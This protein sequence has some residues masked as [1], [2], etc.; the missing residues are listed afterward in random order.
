MSR[1]DFLVDTYA[2]ERMKTLSAWS[3]IPDDRL[4]TRMEPRARTPL[5]HMVH[6]CVSEDTWMKNLGVFIDRPAT[7]STDA[8]LDF[9][10]HYAI[11]SGERLE[12]LRAK[13][14]VWFENAADFFGEARARAWILT[15]RIA[16]SAH[17][18][19]QLL[20]CLRLWGV[21]LYST[22]GP[23]ADTGGLPKH[24]AAVIY[25]YASIDELLDAEARGGSGPRLPGPGGAAVTER[26][27]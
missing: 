3:Q 10:R 24:G 27:S 21:A 20:A 8:R 18:R 4:R 15:R 6:Q 16:H 7:P 19:G 12:A 23:T 14:D 1:Y 9:M 25:R 2:T 26:P 5:E 17:H 22:Y 11:V 13:D